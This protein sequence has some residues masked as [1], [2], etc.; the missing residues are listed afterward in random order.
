MKLV[1]ASILLA[2][3]LGYLRGGRLHQLIDA[4][5]RA[6]WLVLGG[7][8][9]QVL[10]LPSS[11]PWLPVP[12]L[13]LSFVLLMEFAVL[14]LALRGFALILIGIVLNFIVITPNHG[15]PVSRRALIASGQ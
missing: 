11:M 10:P 15:M 5:L 4:K 7:F 8:I 14:N 12:L 2:F 9:L 13:I 6:P 3:L 1:V